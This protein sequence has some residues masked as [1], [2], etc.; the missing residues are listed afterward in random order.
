MLKIECKKDIVPGDTW[1]LTVHYSCQPNAG[2]YFDKSLTEGNDYFVHTYGEGGLHANWLP[3]YNDINDKFSTEMLITVPENYKAISN[4]TLKSIENN[5]GY[6]TYHWKQS[7]PHSNYLIAVYAGKFEKG[8]LRPA[9]NSLPVGYWVHEGGL[10]EGEYT[11]RR[12]TEMIEFFSK[13]F[14]YPYPWEKYDQV[15]IQNFGSAMEHTG[16]TLYDNSVLRSESAPLT[17]GPPDF[18]AYHDFWTADG[19]IA[20]ELAHHWFGNNLTCRNLSYLWLN[21]S[22]AS[23]C[24][25]LWDEED[26]GKET[27]LLDRQVALDWYLYYVENDNIIRPL[28]YHYFEKPDDIYNTEH[29]YFKGAIVLHMLRSILGDGDF[30]RVMH[31]YLKKHEFQNVVSNDFKIAIEEATGQNLD[32]FFDDWVYNGG[33]PIFEVTYTFIAREKLIDLKV[34]QIQPFVKRQDLFRLPVTITIATE[35]GSRSHLIWVEDEEQEFLLECDSQPF[36]VSFDGA[37]NLVAEIKFE[38]Q[39]DELIYQIQKDELP[40]KI[41]ALRQLTKNFPTSSQTIK[42][43][44]GILAGDEFWG[45]KAEA[46]LQLG[47]LRT[48][49]AEQQAAK[50]LNAKDYRIRKAAILGLVQFNTPS[51]IDLLKDVIMNDPQTDVVAAAIVAYAGADDDPEISLI[52]SMIKKHSR[53]YEITMACLEAFGIIGSKSLITD[54][55]PYTSDKYHQDIRLTAFTAWKSCDP[56][57]TALHDRLIEVAV[58][59]PLELQTTAIEFLGELYV[60][61]AKPV[62]KRLIEDSGDEN[63]RV[64]AEKA[65]KQIGRLD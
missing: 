15:A 59:A 39:T 54:I 62:L 17:F 3:I 52:R 57:D 7:L 22:F 55:E 40:G 37:G 41:W 42:T 50:A 14:Q 1:K 31:H 16:I 32:W 34:K 60:Q 49:L 35:N 4:G 5:N 9:L 12:T 43:I 6:Q 45:L 8:E 38:K 23:Y 63:L 11:F 56:E 20:H 51:S 21:E 53:Y 29:T 65:L 44:S 18:Y 13:R 47:V 30:Y 25:M 58:N 36:M 33:H 64:L 61:D 19:T 24:Q 28:E 27:L 26:L 46:A 10:K 48:P 2:M